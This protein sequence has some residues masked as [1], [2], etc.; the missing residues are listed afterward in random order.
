M[1]YIK[2]LADA[3][4]MNMLYPVGESFPKK[5]SKVY[6]YNSNLMYPIRPM[7]VNRQSV[8][9]SSFYNQ[10][11]KDNKLNEGGKNAHFLVNGMHNF[12]IEENMKVKNNPD[13]YYAID[14]VEVGEGN[15]IP[16]WL[17]GFLY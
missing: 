4:L 2:Y 6:M 10:L 8:R 16:L 13:L 5:P 17:F 14:K 1:N 3:R 12:R 7:E 11:L 15:M 9:E